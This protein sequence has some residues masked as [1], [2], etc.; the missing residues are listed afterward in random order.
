MSN[1]SR[2]QNQPD[3]SGQSNQRPLL[4]QRVPADVGE[5]PGLTAPASALAPGLTAA[6]FTARELDTLR[7]ACRDSDFEHL[8]R[9]FVQPA[10]AR[11]AK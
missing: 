7:K 6:H 5:V 3:R 4:G 2:H 11:A 10:I 9:D 8:W 1:A